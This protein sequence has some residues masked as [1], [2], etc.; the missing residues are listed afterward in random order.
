[1]LAQ[2]IVVG[3]DG[4]ETSK[5]ALAWAVEEARLRGAPLLVI[6]AWAYPN[7]AVPELPPF[8]V[9]WE[10]LQEEAHE[11]LE[12]VVAETIG[13][14]AEVEIELVAA[15]GAPAEVLVAAAEDAQLLVVGSRGLGG[16]K[17]LVLGSISHQC[18]QHASCPVVI[19]HRLP[20][21]ARAPAQKPVAHAPSYA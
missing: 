10:L 11:F 7:V 3:V 12:L 16:F 18:A 2:R 13:E 5:Q 4:S 6:Y 21:A 17:E 20:E 19:V 15:R 14:R 1:M 8:A 9:E